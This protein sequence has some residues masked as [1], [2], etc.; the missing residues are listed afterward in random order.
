VI[1]IALPLLQLVV[2]GLLVLVLL[3]RRML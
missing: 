1:V 2:A 3:L